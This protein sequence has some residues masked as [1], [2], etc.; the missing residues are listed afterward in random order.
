MSESADMAEPSEQWP[1][2]LRGG[3]GDGQLF[4]LAE[5]PNMLTYGVSAACY[6]RVPTDGAALEYRFT[7]ED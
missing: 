3:P 5:A 6:V 7:P 1:V 4:H 2:R